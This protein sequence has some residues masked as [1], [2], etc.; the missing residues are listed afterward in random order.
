M[1]VNVENL[2]SSHLTQNLRPRPVG[3]QTSVP[4]TRTEHST[5]AVHTKQDGAQ[6]TTAD[7]MTLQTS[8]LDFSAA[9]VEVDV[10][11]TR[12]KLDANVQIPVLELTAKILTILHQRQNLHQLQIRIQRQRPIQRQRL[13]QSQHR[14]PNQHQIQR[15][16]Q[17]QHQLQTRLQ[18]RASIQ[19]S[20]P[21][22][23]TERATIAALIWRIGAHNTMVDSL[24]LQTST[25]DFNVVSVE[26]DALKKKAV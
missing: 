23:R 4:T 9:S 6:E 8:T 16:L 1:T 10:T 20:V 7:S 19:T 25:L 14:I 24:T 2:M 12:R 13:T 22:T 18:T 26:A 3:I 15:L 17:T 5:I 11:A 21:T